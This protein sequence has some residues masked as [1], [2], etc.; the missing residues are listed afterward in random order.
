[1]L[2]SGYI[3]YAIIE[4][5]GPTAEEISTR[6]GR[7]A[8]IA[9]EHGLATDAM[10]SGVV[11]LSRGTLPLEQTGIKTEPF[12]LLLMKIMEQLKH[13]VRIAYGAEYADFGKLGHEARF[14]YS[15]IAPSFGKVL[16]RLLSTEFGKI[17]EAT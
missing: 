16:G 10:V 15:F 12:S 7:V 3:A 4:V 14:A 17:V 8:K 9:T 2:D 6:M 1:M 5:R 13:D 11:I